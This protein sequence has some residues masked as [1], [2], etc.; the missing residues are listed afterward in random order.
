MDYKT[1]TGVEIATVGM[2]WRASTG[3][4]TCTFEHLADAMTAANDDPHIQIPRLKLGHTSEINGEMRTVDP[5][6]ALGDGA[7]AFGAVTNLRLENSGAVL[8]GD[9]I[10]VP[11]WL[12]DALPSAYRNRSM[13]CRQM[14][15]TD[16]GK[17]YSAVISA[18]ALLGPVIPAIS[19]LADLERFLIE[20]P[21]DD[22]LN[23]ASETPEE[24]RMTPT[25]ELSIAT[26]TI[27]ERF[28]FDWA[29]SE[30]IDGLD[31]YW[32]W[33]RD[34]RVD[35]MEIIA[36]DDEGGCWS[37][38]FTTDG[39]DEVTFGEP[40]KVREEFV[41]I[42][43]SVGKVAASVHQRNSQRVLA[44]GLE[45]PD[46][47]APTTNA[48]T[49]QTGDNEMTETVDLAALRERLS[50][51]ADATEEQINEALKAEETPE[52]PE[53]PETPEEQP[54]ET[55][56]PEAPAEGVQARGV[57]VD[58]DALTQLQSDATAGREARQTQLSAERTSLI[59]A[60][61]G[62]G[63]FPPAAA[64]AYREQLDKGGEIE[65]STRKFI[66][67]LPDNTVPVEE[68]GVATTEAD[69][70]VMAS[71]MTSFGHQPKQAA[72]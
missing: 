41:P 55:P 46:K 48:A 25:A 15:T 1:V 57:T 70:G 4:F 12:A 31:T 53:V 69:S 36:D 34:V 64:A 59:E 54:E 20:G 44:S 58:R 6:A 61:V 42:N 13:E 26:G 33:C 14:V 37:V 49:P 28:N 22:V 2:E 52:T 51:P 3:P 63:K 19:D 24:G 18:V 65:A 35:P 7:P 16:G 67:G 9:Y 62:K 5:F 50:L 32:W 40:V 11:E 21:G 71:I 27:R 17:Q 47:P 39:K 56:E 30:P 29:T 8:V 23:A 60:A 10:E 38:P 43:A 72:A 45:R 66:E 68:T